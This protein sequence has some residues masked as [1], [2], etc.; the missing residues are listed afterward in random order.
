MIKYL[1]FSFNSVLSAKCE[2]GSG[3]QAY[4][5]PSSG[6]NFPRKFWHAPAPS[7]LHRNRL[8]GL[9]E[10]DGVEATGSRGGGGG[11]H[12]VAAWQR[13]L[14]GQPV[15]RWSSVEQTATTALI[16]TPYIYTFQDYYLEVLQNTVKQK[17]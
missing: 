15:G 17:A 2:E 5:I 3:I 6:N 14:E 16:E 4:R 13:A 11:G 8:E 1:N 9:W 12:S 7:L 10:P